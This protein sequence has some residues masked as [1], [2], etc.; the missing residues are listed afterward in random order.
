MSIEELIKE[1]GI[2]PFKATQEEINRAIEI[3]QRDL[4]LAENILGE[5]LDWTYSVAYN[6][7]LQACR[8]YMFHLG[9]RPASAEAHKNTFEF[10][11]FAVDEPFKNSVSYFDRVRRKRHRTIYDEVGL[12]SE[13]EA[14]ELLKRAREFLYL[15]R[16]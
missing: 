13:K 12:V 1:G 11:R 14:R 15:R 4:A 8:A 7:V 5:S 10:M 3:A 6:A 9:Y 2:H 16:G